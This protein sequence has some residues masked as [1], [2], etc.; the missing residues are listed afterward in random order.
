MARRSGQAG[1]A[2]DNADSAPKKETPYQK[3]I[4][5]ADEWYEKEYEKNSKRKPDLED[6]KER[7]TNYTEEIPEP[8]KETKR[9]EEIRERK[10]AKIA[11]KNEYNL[12]IENEAIE[13]RNASATEKLNKEIEAKTKQL[14]KM[15]E[16]MLRN[17]ADATKEWRK[18]RDFNRPSQET[19]EKRK[20]EKAAEKAAKKAEKKA[21]KANKPNATGGKAAIN[22]TSWEEWGKAMEKRTADLNAGKSSAYVNQ[23]KVDGVAVPRPAEGVGSKAWSDPIVSKNKVAQNAYI[24]ANTPAAPGSKPGVFQKLSDVNKSGGAK[25]KAVGSSIAKPFKIA[26]KIAKPLVV[27]SATAELLFGDTKDGYRFQKPD[28]VEGDTHAMKMARQLQAATLGNIFNW[29]PSDIKNNPTSLEW[30]PGFDQNIKQAAQDLGRFGIKGAKL[31]YAIATGQPYSPLASELRASP[32]YQD[33][34]VS[35]E[36]QAHRAQVLKDRAAA[37][38]AGDKGTA[39]PKEQGT[40]FKLSAGDKFPDKDTWVNN[41]D[42]TARAYEVGSAGNFLSYLNNRGKTKEQQ[43][44]VHRDMREKAYPILKAAD[45]EL[46]K[47]ENIPPEDRVAS[48]ELA[49]AYYTKESQELAKI[50]DRQAELRA[51]IKGNAGIEVPEFAANPPGQ[52]KPLISPYDSDPPPPPRSSSFMPGA[53]MEQFI[54]PLDPNSPQGIWQAHI[55]GMAEPDPV[56]ERAKVLAQA[57]LADSVRAGDALING[58]ASPQEQSAYEIYAASQGLPT[59]N[60]ETRRQFEELAGY[61]KSDAAPIPAATT[62]NPIPA[63]S[64]SGEPNNFQVAPFADRNAPMAILGDDSM[65]PMARYYMAQGAGFD[66]APPDA[67]PSKPA[68]GSTSGGAAPAG[69]P[70]PVAARAEALVNAQ[71]QQAARAQAMAQVRDA[72]YEN[73]LNPL[74]RGSGYEELYRAPNP[75]FFRRQR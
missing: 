17:R 37:K 29:T 11:A 46:R 20:A 75:A 67:A 22:T 73:A 5:E 28:V 68:P 12:R 30:I 41:P 66:G 21:A 61:P 14:D 32:E 54:A 72:Y 69:K 1:H 58:G 45:D 26:G 10:N 65:S 36:V 19:I 43:D 40:P 31:A 62:Q 23:P 16:D 18:E 53:A 27:P 51:Q 8:E 71:H 3:S 70:N 63:N 15:K 57:E 25:I 50:A 49:D 52:T 2:G 47:N 33:M 56:A 13:A 7:A 34:E 74:G 42:N 48:S 44:N 39:A 9:Q 60:M 64:I 59:G 24:K 38:Q 4:R 55:Q 35:P 6:L